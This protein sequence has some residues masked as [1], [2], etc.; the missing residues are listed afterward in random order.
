[1]LGSTKMIGLRDSMRRRR[2]R[3]H[4]FEM[5]MQ[6]V[7]SRAKELEKDWESIRDWLAELKAMNR[8]NPPRTW[9]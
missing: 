1:M 3:R 9:E 8:K 2:I 4:A 7:T 6:A 5:E